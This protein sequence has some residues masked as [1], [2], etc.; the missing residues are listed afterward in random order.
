MSAAAMP[1]NPV[2]AFTS[3]EEPDTGFRQI[4]ILVDGMDAAIGTSLIVPGNDEAM[5]IADRLN[6]KLGLDA[7]ELDRLRR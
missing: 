4:R 1:D 5:E 7:G 6:R 2:Y 3:V